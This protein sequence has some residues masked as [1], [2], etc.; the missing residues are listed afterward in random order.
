MLCNEQY[1]DSI[2]GHVGNRLS[3]FIY[4]A[5][6]TAADYCYYTM[7]DYFYTIGVVPES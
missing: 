5:S 6:M 2:K 1:N 4:G 7:C 3:D